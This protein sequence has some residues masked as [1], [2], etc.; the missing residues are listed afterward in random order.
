MGGPADPSKIDAGKSHVQFS[1]DERLGSL[2]L[3][4][5]ERGGVVRLPQLD[6]A[7]S[8]QPDGGEGLGRQIRGIPRTEQI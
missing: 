8:W 1:C 5:D 7:R 2:Y 6:P 4:P 3:K